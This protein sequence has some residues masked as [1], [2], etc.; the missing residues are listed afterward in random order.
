[1]TFTGEVVALEPRL[2]RDRPPSLEVVCHELLHRLALSQM[3]RTWNDADTKEVVERIAR[4]NGLSAEGPAGSREHLLQGNVTDAIFLRRAA[5][6]MGHHL[7]IEG[8]KLVIAPPPRAAEVKIGPA[9][10]LRKLRVQI[11]AGRQV[12]EVSVHG[13][14]AKAKREIVARASGEGDPGEG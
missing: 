6:Q 4:E 5:R 7:R 1:R 9:S 14:D 12:S 13:W 2:L 10:G 8:R 3:T 11:R